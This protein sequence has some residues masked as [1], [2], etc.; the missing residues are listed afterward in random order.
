MSS[1]WLISDRLLDWLYKDD[2]YNVRHQS[3]QDDRASNSGVWFLTKF[4]NWLQ[5]SSNVLV[6]YGPGLPSVESAYYLQL[7]SENHF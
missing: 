6:C 2:N 5:Q 7:A 1:L 3:I 4:Q